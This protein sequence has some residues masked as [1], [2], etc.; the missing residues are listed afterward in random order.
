M[1]RLMD[2][3]RIKKQGGG[4]NYVHGGISLQGAVVPVI[5]FKIGIAFVNDFDF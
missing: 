5:E 3:I 2:N 1:L 4:M